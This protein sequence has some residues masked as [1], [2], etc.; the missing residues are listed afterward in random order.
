MRRL[1]ASGPPDTGERGLRSRDRSTYYNSDWT[2]RPHG[3]QYRELVFEEW[4]TDERGETDEDGIY[5]IRGFNGS[6]RITAEK[7]ALS[8]QAAVTFDDENGSVTIELT[9]PSENGAER[10]N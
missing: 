5:T 6:Y 8:G 3:E 4:W 2:L 10:R 1:V 7:G 9:P